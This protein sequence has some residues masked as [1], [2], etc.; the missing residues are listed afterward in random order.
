M[1]VT[2]LFELIAMITI[3]ISICLQFLELVTKVRGLKTVR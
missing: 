3:A 2:G 1:L